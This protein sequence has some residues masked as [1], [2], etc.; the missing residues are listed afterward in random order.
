M[1]KYLWFSLVFA[2]GVSGCGNK[3]ATPAVAIPTKPAAGASS[4]A[5]SSEEKMLNIYN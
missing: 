5:L 1:N 4:D 3:E 2:A